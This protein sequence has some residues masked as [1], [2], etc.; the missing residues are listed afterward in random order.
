MA[1]RVF[2]EFKGSRKY[3]FLL[4]VIHDTVL[5]WLLLG[6]LRYEQHLEQ[7]GTNHKVLSRM[8]S[9]LYFSCDN[10]ITPSKRVPLCRT[11]TR[12]RVQRRGSNAAIR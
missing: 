12:R 9:V 1:I 5:N 11:C 3:V 4:F 2:F 7:V 10:N 8:F 6:L